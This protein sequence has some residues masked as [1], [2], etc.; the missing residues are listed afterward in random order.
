MRDKN[1]LYPK[2]FALFQLMT[3]L[4]E[5]ETRDGQL[6]RTGAFANFHA[7]RILP[8][9]YDRHGNADHIPIGP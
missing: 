2:C 6:M 9:V 1:W 5:R 4:R 7:L 8:E 3:Q